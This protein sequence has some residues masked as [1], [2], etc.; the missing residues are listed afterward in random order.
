[1]KSSKCTSLSRHL[2]LVVRCYCVCVMLGCFD[3][4]LLLF[5]QQAIFRRSFS[6]PKASRLCF[7]LRVVSDICLPTQ[8]YQTCSTVPATG[9]AVALVSDGSR[10]HMNCV[11]LHHGVC[12]RNIEYEHGRCGRCLLLAVRERSYCKKRTRVHDSNLRP[13]SE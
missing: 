11:T 5:V 12:L 8:L 2:W 9:S 3:E 4:I 6:V 10:G 7:Q 1:M 13:I